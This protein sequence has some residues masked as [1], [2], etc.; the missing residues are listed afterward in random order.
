MADADIISVCLL[1]R[2]CAVVLVLLLMAGDVERNPGP[3]LKEGNFVIFKTDGGKSVS[4]TVTDPVRI[5]ASKSMSYL[6]DEF[7]M[8]PGNE[9]L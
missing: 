1:L 6:N 9:E 5:T 3:T 7:C 2:V 8:M 4:T